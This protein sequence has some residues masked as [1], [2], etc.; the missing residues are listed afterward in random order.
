MSSEAIFD[1]YLVSQTD[2]DSGALTRLGVIVHQL[3]DVGR[4]EAKV[5]RAGRSEGSFSVMVSEESHSAQARINLSHP[6]AEAKACECGAEH[7]HEVMP[8]GYLVLLVSEGPGGHSVL[9]GPSDDPKATPFDSTRLTGGDRFAITILRPGTYGVSNVLT[10]AEARIKVAYPRVGR[11]PSAPPKPVQIAC[12]EQGFV[13]SEANVRAGQ[14][15]VYVCRTSS[16]IVI[17]L[18]EPDDRA[19]NSERRLLA[20]W[21]RSSAREAT[22]ARAR[23]RQ[24]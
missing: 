12:T 19:P 15:L 20:G 5:V 8:K 7:A 2:L 3:S 10:G 9:L 6:E 22:R 21:S 1:R 17:R 24:R 16:R 13:P 18:L 11:R 14:G 4:F 23:P